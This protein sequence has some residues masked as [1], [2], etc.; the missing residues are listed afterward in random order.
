MLVEVSL[1]TLGRHSHRNDGLRPQFR[2]QQM[3]CH[4]LWFRSEE[5]R[6]RQERDEIM[7]CRVSSLVLALVVT[8]VLATPMSTYA[9][10]SAA[11]AVAQSS[12]NTSTTI[13]PAEAAARVASGKFI[14]DTD[15][16]G[17]SPAVVNP[18]T[19][20]A[21]NVCF[22]C[23]GDWPIFAGAFHAVNTG[24]QT[25]ER[26]SA[27]SGTLHSSNDTNPFLCCK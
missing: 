20:V 2:L 1:D 10:D 25:F 13:S 9:Q 11:A 16:T 23:G 18:Q 12:T 24:L 27:C 14:P 26:G 6:R 3:R 5:R 8:W 7:K 17:I 21:C 4:A 22:T 15:R 19:S